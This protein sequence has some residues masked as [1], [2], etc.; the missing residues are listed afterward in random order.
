M[1]ETPTKTIAVPEVT[2]LDVAFGR[3]DFLPQRGTLPDEYREQWSSQI[4]YCRAISKWFFHGAECDGRALVIDGE[5]FVPK[6]GI[7]AQKALRAISA[8]LRSFEPKHEHKIGACG[9][10]L[11]QW[12]EHDDD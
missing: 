10:L 9:F 8:A 4:P 11:S 12:F 6:K 3:I 7:D 5:R 2:D 1:N